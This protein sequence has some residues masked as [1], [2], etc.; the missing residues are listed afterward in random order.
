MVTHA[1]VLFVDI[2]GFT[3]WSEGIEAFQ[4]IDEFINKFYNILDRHFP[5][6]Y[7][8][9]LG[10]GAM[11]VKKIV[12]DVNVWVT[13]EIS[14]QL[15]PREKI[16]E[17]PEVH[18]AGLC[19]KIEEDKIEALI[20]RRNPNRKLFPRLYE[21]CGGQLTYSESFIE[22]VKR[23][24]RLEMHIDVDVVES[25]HKFYEIVESN[26]PLIPGIE[27]LCIYRGGIPKSENHSEIKWVNEEELNSIHSNEFIPYLKDDFIDFIE[28][29]KACGL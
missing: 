4:Y 24:F 13:P 11:I 29:F 12:D 5:D 14:T 9:K 8:K 6:T 25:I 23:H 7:L 20:A 28:K 1:I 16:R 18:V 22:G 15:I 27:F 19:I 21:G 26:E 17:T 10:D 3:R 2:R